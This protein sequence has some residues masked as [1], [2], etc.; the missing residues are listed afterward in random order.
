MGGRSN[1]KT[2]CM[3]NCMNSEL[4][5]DL[6]PWEWVDLDAQFSV[7]RDVERD[8]TWMWGVAGAWIPFLVGRRRDQNCEF[9][10]CVAQK[11]N[12]YTR[13]FLFGQNQNV[14]APQWKE[15]WEEGR[16]GHLFCLNENKELATPQDMTWKVFLCA[17]GVGS[18]QREGSFPG[19]EDGGDIVQHE[20][21][22]FKWH[23]EGA[24]QW[25]DKPARDWFAAFKT[26]ANEENSD[27]AFAALWAAKERDERHELSVTTRRD[28]LALFLRMLRLFI[29]SDGELWGG[30]PPVGFQFQLLDDEAPIKRTWIRSK[31]TDA[32]PFSLRFDRLWEWLITHFEPKRGSELASF[33]CV[34]QWLDEYK[35]SLFDFW[36]T[37]P[38][39]HER[40]EALL[41]LRDLLQER[42]LDAQNLLD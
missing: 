40:L 18:W 24:A 9:N 23:D 41:E 11:G 16:V 32:V 10:L 37:A 17:G 38:T 2:P 14:L 19:Q 1:I 39:Q 31:R 8:E 15:A 3:R 42:G 27:V 30:A 20:P 29:Q 33:S 6:A 34:K 7:C 36:T 26:L 4:H 22:S 21:Q 13:W 5:L 28:S 35:P 25:L 12:S